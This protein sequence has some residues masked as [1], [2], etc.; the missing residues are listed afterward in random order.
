MSGARG[1]GRNNFVMRKIFH[2]IA[3][4]AASLS[5]K[6]LFGCVAHIR[7]LRR[8][9]AEGTGG[10]LLASNHISHFDPVI[11]SSDVHRNIDWM[12]MSEFFPQ[13]IS[14]LLR[15]SVDSY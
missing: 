2:S 13:P 14:S 12:T 15:P 6:L 1:R 3:N 7:V 10:Y 9:N 5:A 8:E 4:R 11:I